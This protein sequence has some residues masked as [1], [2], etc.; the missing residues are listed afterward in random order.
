MQ[1]YT[2]LT[3]LSSRVLK[4]QHSHWGLVTIKCAHQVKHRHFLK[5]E[6]EFLYSNTRS[7]TSNVWPTY[8]D[9]FFIHH[10]DCLTLTHMSGKTLLEIHNSSNIQA[11]LPSHWLSTLESAINQIHTLGFIHGDIKPSNIVISQ[12]GQMQLI[13]FGSVTKIGT[14]RAALRFESYTPQYSRDY[15]VTSQVDDWFSLAVILEQLF[16]D[17]ALPSR[18]Q[19]LLKQQR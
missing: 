5:Q 1:G 15:F 4:A 6:A 3:R 2:H 9:Y 14:E 19:T 8:C 17:A 11:S 7:N 16:D 18:Y 12:Q 10:C 13:D